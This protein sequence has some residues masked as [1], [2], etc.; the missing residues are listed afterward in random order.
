MF[1]RCAPNQVQL[2]LVVAKAGAMRKLGMSDEVIH[3]MA[4]NEFARIERIAQAIDVI[5]RLTAQGRLT[6]VDQEKLPP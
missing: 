1:P 6:I 5:E 3:E 4:K 2:K